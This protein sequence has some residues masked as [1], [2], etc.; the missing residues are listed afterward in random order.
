MKRGPSLRLLLT[1]LML[2]CFVSGCS[3]EDRAASAL[4]ELGE[5]YSASELG[6]AKRLSEFTTQYEALAEKYAGT[7]AA[8]DA[9]TW[10]ITGTSA[11]EE[12]EASVELANLKEAYAESEL[13]RT[14]KNEEFTSRYEALAGEFWGT[15][16]ALEAK[17]WLIRRAPRDARSATI[18]EATDAIFA[19][20]A[21]SPH[22]KRLGDLMSS[23]S[24][25]QREKYFGGL[26]EN[27]PHAE[28]RA[29]VIYDLARYKK[30]YMR[31]GMV[32]DAP[33][34]REQVEADLN[35]LMEEYADLPTGGSTYGVMADALLN[36]YTDEEL[37]IG[38][39]AP[40]I[41]GVTADGKDIRL[42]QFLGRVVVIDFWGDW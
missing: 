16:A 36:A 26:R 17:F 34:T 38:Q 20:Y 29:A 2:A 24:V 18:G 22:I 42:G 35:L 28:V 39:R 6:L 31:Y 32:E 4:A 15:E 27:S 33:E 8:V 9:E 19:R 11:A 23:F 25:E 37:A 40:E 30:R 3:K 7:R 13:S 41:I 1:S 10:L 21:E 5:A 14:E 12:E